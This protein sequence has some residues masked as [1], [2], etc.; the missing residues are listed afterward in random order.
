MTTQP[1]LEAGEEIHSWRANTE[2]NQRKHPAN[3]VLKQKSS[4]GLKGFHFL[5]E[6][7]VP[8]YCSCTM[9]V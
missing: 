3:R 1:G 4:F 9:I 2:K 6:P 7:L 8:D 5:F